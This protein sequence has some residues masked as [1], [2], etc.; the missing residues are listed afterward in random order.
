MLIK[1][2]E[3]LEEDVGRFNAV[4]SVNNVEFVSQWLASIIIIASLLGG[5]GE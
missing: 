3:G 5:W 2:S 1:I 4:R